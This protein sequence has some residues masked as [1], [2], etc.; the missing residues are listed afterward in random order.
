MADFTLTQAEAIE[1]LKRSDAVTVTA[2]EIAPCLK[3][4]PGVLRK[5]VRDGTYSLSQ[6]DYDPNQSGTIR[7]FRKD[8]LQKIGEIPP[9]PEEDIPHQMCILLAEA[10]EH[11]KI[12]ERMIACIMTPHQRDVFQV[13]IAEE[14]EKERAKEKTAG[15]GTPTD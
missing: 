11:L 6:V 1:R 15:A 9:D 12:I 2:D 3:M 14:V 7:F 5:R 8:F 10:T 13:A 4:N